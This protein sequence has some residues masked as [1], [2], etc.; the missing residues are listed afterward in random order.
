MGSGGPTPPT[1]AGGPPPGA[2]AGGPYPPGVPPAVTIRPVTR[3]GAR[4]VPTLAPYD[5][6]MVQGRLLIVNPRDM[7]VAEVIRSPRKAAA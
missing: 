4:H 5:F 6:A 1:G 7:I 3:K 2:S